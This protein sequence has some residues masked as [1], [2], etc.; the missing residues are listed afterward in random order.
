MVVPV[1]DLENK[2]TSTTSNMI[3]T[4]IFELPTMSHSNNIGMDI[5]AGPSPDNYDEVRGRSLSTKGNI[6]RDSSMFSTKS[7]IV[8]YKKI[9]HNNSIVVDDEMG[10]IFPALSYKTDQEKVL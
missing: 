6:S 10:N 3:P 7:S 2:F 1:R 9:E 4:Q 5:F 8:Y